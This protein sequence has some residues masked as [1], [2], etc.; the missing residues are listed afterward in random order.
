MDKLSIEEVENRI[1]SE[2]ISLEICESCPLSSHDNFVEILQQLLDTMR[3]NERLREALAEGARCL[4]DVGNGHGGWAWEQVHD[5]MREL[6]NKD[7]V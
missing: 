6:S 3:E 5:N 2:N 1:K 4:W 7:S